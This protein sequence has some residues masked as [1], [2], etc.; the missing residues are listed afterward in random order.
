[1]RVAH[2]LYSIFD[3]VGER[4]RHLDDGPTHQLLK[5]QHF[6]RL[7]A[8]PASKPDSDQYAKNAAIIGWGLLNSGKYL[9]NI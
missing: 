4:R 6:T 9:V 2:F 3:G 7:L 5:G 8:A 1:L